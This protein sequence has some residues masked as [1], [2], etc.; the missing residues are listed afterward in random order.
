MWESR[1]VSE[2]VPAPWDIQM[3]MCSGQLDRRIL[4]LE[5]S[6]GPRRDSQ[7]SFRG[8]PA[9]GEALDRLSQ[10]AAFRDVP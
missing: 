10:E 5:E 4:S 9:E 6:L 7:L 1:G 3:G 8:E 2:Y